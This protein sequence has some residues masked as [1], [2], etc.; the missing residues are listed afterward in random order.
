MLRGNSSMS[1]LD[2][3][4]QI[5]MLAHPSVML[6]HRALSA[7][8]A[9]RGIQFSPLLGECAKLET[10]AVLQRLQTG[11]AGLEEAEAAQ[12]LAQGGPNVVVS[13]RHCGWPWRL[14]AAARNPLVILLVVLAGISFA[15]GD[16]R[17]G[18]VMALMVVLGV[19]LRFV[20]ETRADAAAAK[21]K[22]MITVTT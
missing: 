12:R 5:E 22:A 11:A 20:Q 18:T 6:A 4:D 7:K 8:A 17:A 19:T 9:P 2:S 10:A 21:L 16:S 13:E 15:T 14:F 1:T 3:I